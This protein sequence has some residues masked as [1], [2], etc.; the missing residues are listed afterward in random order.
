MWLLEG[1]AELIAPTRCAGCELPGSVLCEACTTSLPRVNPVRACPRCAA[2]YGALVCTECWDTVYA[3]ESAICLGELRAQL[4]RAVVLHKDAGERRLGATLGG[5]LGVEVREAW[6]AWGDA[7][8]WIPPT[9]A[10]IVRRG[11]DHGR[12]IAEPVARALALAAEGLLVRPHA[13]DQ[14]ALGRSARKTSARGSFSVGGP[15]PARVV[16]VDDVMTTGAT[17][18]A[19]AQV[20]LAAGAEAVRVAVVSR[21]W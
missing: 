21:A 11:F 9:H 18:D 14:R 5:L 3:F 10:A 7:V 19:A 2:P 4:A 8:C 17:L 13:R 16:V 15:V 20:L 6:G 12:S 1:I